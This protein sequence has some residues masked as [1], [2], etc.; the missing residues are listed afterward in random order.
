[1]SMDAGMG[2]SI[3]VFMCVCGVCDVK[4][5][6]CVFGGGSLFIIY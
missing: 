6:V 5:C 3:D 4:V 2:L 1:M